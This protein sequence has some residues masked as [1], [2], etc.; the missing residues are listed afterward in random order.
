MLFFVCYK[1]L[2]NENLSHISKAVPTVLLENA[3]LR[4]TL[5]LVGIP[6]VRSL[7]S[8]GGLQDQERLLYEYLVQN[9]SDGA[10]TQQS[11]MGQ[12]RSKVSLGVE[13]HAEFFSLLASVMLYTEISPFVMLMVGGKHT[14]KHPLICVDLR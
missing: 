12:A 3:G 13:T 10:N 7:K 4:R 14:G 1:I 9:R 11:M 5:P 6:V 2:W 8:E